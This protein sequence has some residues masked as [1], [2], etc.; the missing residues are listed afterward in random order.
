MLQHHHAAMLET[1][2]ETVQTVDE[3]VQK[4]CPLTGSSGCTKI[5]A[6]AA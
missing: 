1:G 4:G 2:S 3:S 6:A 5:S